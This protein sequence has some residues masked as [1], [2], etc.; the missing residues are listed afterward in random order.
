MEAVVGWAD[1]PTADETC[2]N[3]RERIPGVSHTTICRALEAL[4]E[5]GVL[6]GCGSAV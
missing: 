2:D 3:V 6:A 4:V 1:C 5:V